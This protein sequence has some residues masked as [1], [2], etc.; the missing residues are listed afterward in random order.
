MKCLLPACLLLALAGCAQN[1]QHSDSYVHAKVDSIVG[2][3]MEEINRQA[4]EDLDQRMSIEVQQKADSILA[5]RQ[6]ARR[7]PDSTAAAKTR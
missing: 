6:A 2:V 3:R 7:G 4:M 5:A 1:N